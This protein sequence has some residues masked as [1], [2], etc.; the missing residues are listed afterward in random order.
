MK[1]QS[2]PHV[3]VLV[4]TPAPMK[5]I[6]L[7]ALDP[8]SVDVPA[9]KKLQ[10]LIGKILADDADDSHR[11]EK[12][13][14]QRKIRGRPAQNPLRRTERRLDG[15]ERHSPH[16]QNAHLF[17]PKSKIRYPKSEILIDISR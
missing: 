16:N 12:T 13:R 1:L 10:V 15:I 9:S 6:A 3:D 7:F 4:I 5:S 2:V 17:D 11:S 14:R 8:V